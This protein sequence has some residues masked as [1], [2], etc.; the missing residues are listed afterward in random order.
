MLARNALPLSW[1]VLQAQV[2]EFRKKYD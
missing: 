1:F 2:A